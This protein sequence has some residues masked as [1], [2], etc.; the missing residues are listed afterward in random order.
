MWFFPTFGGVTND[1]IQFTGDIAKNFRYRS[2]KNSIIRIIM[3]EGIKAEIR[4]VSAL[5]MPLASSRKLEYEALPNRER[6]L[7]EAD[8]LI[9]EKL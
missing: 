8:S 9:G 3:E 2:C 6:I 5:D 4:V 1:D 7:K